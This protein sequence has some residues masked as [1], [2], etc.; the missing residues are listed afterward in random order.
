MSARKSQYSPDE[1]GALLL[2]HFII[3]WDLSH[4]THHITDNQCGER[5]VELMTVKLTR[6]IEAQILQYSGAYVWS[7]LHTCCFPCC[8]SE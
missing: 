2:I 6:S 8:S 5:C 7:E 1:A 4:G 3:A